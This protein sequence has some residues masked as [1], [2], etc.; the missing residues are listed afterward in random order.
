MRNL[1]I[2]IAII[3]GTAAIAK[4]QTIYNVN[5]ASYLSTDGQW[6][7]F[8][9]VD[10]E[11]AVYND[12]VYLKVDKLSLNLKVVLKV[13]GKTETPEGDTITVLSSEEDTILYGVVVCPHQSLTI[14]RVVG[15][16]FGIQFLFS[17]YKTVAKLN[18]I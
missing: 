12:T 8:Q 17:K 2:L 10:G 6:S 9:K 16:D 15:K 7:G 13:E 18:T 14:F 1:I 3:L 5:G 11:L 4:S